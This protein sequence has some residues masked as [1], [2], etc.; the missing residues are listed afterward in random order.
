MANGT[1]CVSALGELVPLDT[2]VCDSAAV[3]ICGQLNGRVLLCADTDW[4][5]AHAEGLAVIVNAGSIQ[6]LIN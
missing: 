2:I 1:T 4:D 3:Q 5:R 6:L